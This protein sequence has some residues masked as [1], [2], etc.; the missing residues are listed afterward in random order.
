MYLNTSYL[1]GSYIP[2]T[3]KMVSGQFFCFSRLIRSSTYSKQKISDFPP[4]G[5]GK[6]EGGKSRI[7]HN[8]YRNLSSYLQICKSSVARVVER[9][10][11]NQKISG[12]KLDGITLFYGKCRPT[13]GNIF[14][15]I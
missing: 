14:S 9:E 11:L 4:C 6:R 13:Q 12:T 8:S 1:A 10:T 7:I 3:L 5:K 2:F 15:E